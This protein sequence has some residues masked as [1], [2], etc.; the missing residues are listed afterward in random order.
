VVYNKPYAEN[1]EPEAIAAA[2][3]PVL[4]GAFGV[5]Y[6]MMIGMGQ[7]YLLELGWWGYYWLLLI[8]GNLVCLVIPVLI[9]VFYSY[10]K[11]GETGLKTY[12][13]HASIQILDG[14]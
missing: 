8:G 7:Y 14:G 5:C 6:G 9:F 1:R 13:H 12:V 10:L 2:Y 3:A 11:Y 4:F